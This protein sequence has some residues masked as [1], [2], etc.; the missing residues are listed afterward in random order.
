[1]K[2]MNQGISPEEM[3]A[4]YGEIGVKDDDDRL[5]FGSKKFDVVVVGKVL[6]CSFEDLTV[7]TAPCS[8]LKGTT[9]SIR[10]KKLQ[11]VSPNT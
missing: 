11:G 1:M 5:E 8:A 9:T 7:L 2:V 3:H 6:L 10:S 4:I